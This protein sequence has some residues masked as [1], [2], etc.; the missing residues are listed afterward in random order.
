[1]NQNNRNN[2]VKDLCHLLA[3][4]YTLYTKT[5]YF[6]WNITGELFFMLHEAFEKQYK[7]LA[8]A[9]DVLAERIRA[10]GQFAPGTFKEFQEIASIKLEPK[11]YSAQEMVKEL[12]LGHEHLVQELEKMIK[13]AGE[14]GDEATMDLMIQ[15][16][17]HH[18]KLA[19]ML[20]SSLNHEKK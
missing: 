10:L 3:D 14:E 19:W 1:M 18:Q 12:L 5:Q 7:E 9:I 11:I 4:T 15:R 8:E 17:A 13:S 2:V 20:R 6:H 16:Q